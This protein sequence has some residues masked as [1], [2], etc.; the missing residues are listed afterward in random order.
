MEITPFELVPATGGRRSSNLCW[1]WRGRIRNL[2]GLLYIRIQKKQ[3]GIFFIYQVLVFASWGSIYVKFWDFTP[4]STTTDAPKKENYLVL[5]WYFNGKQ[6]CKKH[7]PRKTRVHKWFPGEVCFPLG[8][9]KSSIHCSSNLTSVLHN[10]VVRPAEKNK[11]HWRP[12]L[13]YTIV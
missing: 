7:T 6:P 4:T 11:C 12:P 5:C 3:K 2:T 1:S 8:F 10:S 13:A 9:P